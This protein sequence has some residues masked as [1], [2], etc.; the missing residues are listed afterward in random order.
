MTY[1]IQIAS[2]KIDIEGANFRDALG[3]FLIQYPN[4]AVRVIGRIFKEEG[5]KC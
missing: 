4:L 1:T 2:A 5:I 3:R